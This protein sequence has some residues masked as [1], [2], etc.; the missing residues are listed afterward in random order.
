MDRGRARFGGLFSE[1]DTE[2]IDAL[3]FATR[4]NI[5]IY[6]IDP[7]RPAPPGVTGEDGVDAQSSELRR[8]HRAGWPGRVTGGFSLTGSNNYTQAFERLV[9]ENSTY[10]LLAFNSGVDYRDGRY[11]RLEVRV[12]RP[13][14][15]VRST[16]GYVSPRG[17]QQ[18]PA[19]AAPDDGPGRHLGCGDERDHHERRVD[20]RCT[21]RHSRAR[22]RTPLSPITLEIA[23]DKL[24]LVEED[25]AYRGQLEVIFAVTDAKKR[26]LP[27][28]A[29]SLWRSR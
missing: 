27:I 6:P 22:T 3:S 16:E 15:Q 17:K 19:A 7:A 18:Q 20:A 11:V 10:Y 24:N 26:R 29:A 2:W 1:V 23:P 13:G 5:A 4:N 9:R 12:K 8:P 28:C 21:R 14:L 25:G